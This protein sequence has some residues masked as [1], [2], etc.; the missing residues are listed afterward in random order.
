M[1]KRQLAYPEAYDDA[2][3]IMDLE[4]YKKLKDKY[5]KL[6]NLVSSCGT[7]FDSLVS[8]LGWDEE[9]MIKYVRGE[10]PNLHGKS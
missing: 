7:G 8:T 2:D 6:N 3:R 1:R 10:R 5:D 9:E 4:F